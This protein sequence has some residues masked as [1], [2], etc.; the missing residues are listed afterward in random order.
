M[1]ALK[2]SIVLL[3]IVLTLPGC[4]I[5]QDDR[6][7]V[8]REWS[9]S[10]RELG[11]VPVF[12]PREDFYVGDIYAYG[13]DPGGEKALRLWETPWDELSELEQ[14]CRAMIGMSPRLTRLSVLNPVIA[15]EYGAT[16]SAP[17]TSRDF[18]EI[19]GNPA[20]G[21]AN[22]KVAAA[23]KVVSTLEAKLAAAVK[24]EQ[25]LTAKKQELAWKQSD[26]QQ[27]ADNATTALNTAKQE[28]VDSTAEQ[29]AWEQ[30]KREQMTAEDAYTAAQHRSE[31]LAPATGA[32]PSTEY[33]QAKIDEKAAKRAKDKAVLDTSRAK[34]AYD[35]KKTQPRDVSVEQ[36]NH[37]A[38]QSNLTSATKAVTDIERDIKRAQDRRQAVKLDVD[39]KLPVAKAKLNDLVAVRNAIA[40]AGAGLLQTQPRDEKRNFYTGDELSPKGVS[41]DDAL[42][43]RANRMRLVAFPEF[44]TASFSQGDLSALVPIEAMGLGLNISRSSI[45]RVSVKVP[46]AESYGISV[47]ALLEAVLQKGVPQPNVGGRVL[48]SDDMQK[49]VPYAT[50]VANPSACQTEAKR[51]QDGSTKQK[52]YFRVISEVFYARALDIAL[53]SADSFGVSAQVADP[54]RPI[55]ALTAGED[56]SQLPEMTAASLDVESLDSATATNLL[57][58]LQNRLG[59]TRQIPGGSIQIVNYSDRSIGLRRVFDRPIAIGFRGVNL[60]YDLDSGAVDTSIKSGPDNLQQDNDVADTSGGSGAAA[61]YTPA[62]AQPGGTIPAHLTRDEMWGIFQKVIGDGSNTMEDP[63]DTKK[64]RAT[65]PSPIPG[66]GASKQAIPVRKDSLPAQ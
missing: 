4:P 28:K 3:A 38:A 65:D 64:T 35:A 6:L 27:L 11:I 45:D 49:M 33:Q 22:A 37:D 23:K 15:Q 34:A 47:K 21:A 63:M 19:V 20:V 31:D 57:T 60:A 12:P 24:A 59:M 39:A 50:I 5:Q 52:I 10:L 13:Y 61:D 46:A 58:R 41:P 43:S 56:T 51:Q 36:A 66:S 16:L 7:F 44:S 48:L 42:G 25:D 53:F 9:K 18:S 62:W 32:E 54:I 40:Q 14:G 26:A 8:Q 55:G 2:V 1:K 30:A 17:K 29:K